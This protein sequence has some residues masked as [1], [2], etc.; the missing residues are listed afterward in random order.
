MDSTLYFLSHHCESILTSGYSSINKP[1]KTATGVHEVQ[2]LLRYLSAIYDRHI[3]R[4]DEDSQIQ[5]INQRNRQT[6]VSSG[7]SRHSSGISA[8]DT[9]RVISSF[10]FAFIWAFGGHLHERYFL[11]T[12]NI[13]PLDTHRPFWEFPI[14]YRLGISRHICDSASRLFFMEKQKH[15]VCCCTRFL[16]LSTRRASYE[17]VFSVSFTQVLRP[18]IK[19]L[20]ARLRTTPTQTAKASFE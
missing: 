5:M 12:S 18:I 13:S 2:S 7:S 14:W 15:I 1:S 9:G 11:T 17:I 10:A 19:S 16:E 3:L 6:S 20:Y 4:E 8:S